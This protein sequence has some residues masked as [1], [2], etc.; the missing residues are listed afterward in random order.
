LFFFGN[1]AVQGQRR[2]VSGYYKLRWYAHGGTYAG[3]FCLAA[4]RTHFVD[5]P[6]DFNELNIEL[7]MRL[8]NR[9]PRLSIKLTP[10]Q[11][12]RLV[13][14]LHRQPDVTAAYV[15]EVRRLEKIN[16]RVSGGLKYINFKR[17]TSYSWD[18]VR[19]IKGLGRPST[20]PRLRN[21]GP[22]NAWRC[23]ICESI[24]PSRS[25]LKLCPACGAQ[26]TLHA[27]QSINLIN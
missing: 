27:H 22:M 6:L 14:L 25:L 12:E 4:E 3:D 11:S 9:V 1:H 2:G 10:A 13:Q 5:R 21:T 16:A 20:R 15:G 8:S 17:R 7:G 26:G 19:D 23:D 18:S 24:N